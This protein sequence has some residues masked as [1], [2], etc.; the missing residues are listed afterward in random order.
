MK[1]WI[2][3]PLAMML[4]GCNSKVEES[5]P[6]RAGQQTEQGRSDD[7]ARRD[8]SESVASG[9]TQENGTMLD[10]TMN[11]IDG[12][13]ESLDAYKGKVVMVVNVASKCGLTPQ[14]D[15][16]E[17]MYE[18]YKDQGLV[19][20]GFPA[21]DFGAQEP[22]TNAEIQTFCTSEYG[23]TFP[24]FE[25]ITVTGDQAHPFYKQLTE[26]SEAPSW[27]FTKYLIDRNG[28]FVERIDPRTTPED[29]A[30]VS[31]IETL[32]KG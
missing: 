23:V 10:V 5:A 18:K 13:P 17:S 29:A 1:T 30:V 14:Y 15:Q 12:T 2:I 32:L 7:I 11:R 24:M 6:A 4:A 27:N 9:T 16:L 22:G 28:H 19:I 20:L 8:L 21:N 25:K 31:Q 26:L 3:I